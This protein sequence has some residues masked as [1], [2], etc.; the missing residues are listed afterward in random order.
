[1][2]NSDNY[3]TIRCHQEAI[4]HARTIK[5]ENGWTWTRFMVRALDA[6]SDESI[7]DI[8]PSE[9]RDVNQGRKRFGSWAE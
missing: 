8:E 6:L 5:E 9:P 3:S 7:D 4:D 2:P 1:M